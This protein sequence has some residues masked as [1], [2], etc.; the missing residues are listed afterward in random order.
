VS[1]VYFIKHEFPF[2]VLDVYAVTRF[3]KEHHTL[4]ITLPVVPPARNV[5]P[6]SISN[7]VNAAQE[8]LAK[9]ADFSYPVSTS[10]ERPAETQPPSTMNKRSRLQP[11]SVT[12]ASVLADSLSTS[13]VLPANKQQPSTLNKRSRVQPA[14]GNAVS[15]TDASVTAFT[16]ASVKAHFLNSGDKAEP[17]AAPVVEASAEPAVSRSVGVSYDGYN[18]CMESFKRIKWNVDIHRKDSPGAGKG[19]FMITRVLK[20]DCVACYPGHLVDDKG[21]VVVSC[22]LTESLFARLP[23][24]KRPFSRGHGV[25][26][27]S[28]ACPHV[29]IV[30]GEFEY[31]A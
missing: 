2:P 4:T 6:F 24:V 12:G 19:I 18:K 13:D 16:A 29:L 9:A 3:N 25:N 22:P 27:N 23:T 1:G 21:A 14:P 30:D 17:R 5:A 20:T 26:V 11:A 15:V 8:N 7:L 31:A 28:V 10:E